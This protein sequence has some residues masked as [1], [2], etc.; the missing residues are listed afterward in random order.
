MVALVTGALVGDPRSGLSILTTVLPQAMAY[1]LL[2]AHPGGVDGAKARPG[3]GA[4]AGRVP[5]HVI[6]SRL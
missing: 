3:A 5:Q 2:A 6:R 4:E 1:N